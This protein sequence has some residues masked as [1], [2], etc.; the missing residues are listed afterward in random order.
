MIFMNQCNHC[1]SWEWNECVKSDHFK[2][3]NNKKSSYQDNDEACQV[4]KK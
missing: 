1:E 2:L 3:W 4:R